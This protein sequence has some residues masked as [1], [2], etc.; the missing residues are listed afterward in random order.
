MKQPVNK[1]KFRQSLL[2]RYLLIIGFA[3]LF[4]PLVFPILSIAYFIA[5]SIWSG[6]NDAALKYGSFAQLE[7]AWHAEAA[8]MGGWSAEQIN[9]RMEELKQQ[10]ADGEL[11]WVDADG[12]TQLQLP[13]QSALPAQWTQA[14]AIRFMKQS[15]GSDP[16]TVVSFL[17]SE[18]EEAAF[19]VIQMPRSLMISTVSSVEQFPFFS[20]V[21]IIL[22]LFAVLSLLFFRHI[23]K[24]LMRLEASMSLEGSNGLPT[25]VFVRKHDEIGQLEAAFNRMIDQL[26]AGQ[27]RE[28]EEEQLRKQLIANLSHDLRT[29][30]TVMG[31]QLYSLRKETKS[32]AGLQSIG[33]L[34]SKVADLS[35][36]IDN[37][38]SYTL[39]TSGRYPLK[40]ERHDV[41]RLAK[42]TA[43]AWYPLW[44]K[45][46]LEADIRLEP[47]LEQQPGDSAPPLIWL[48]DRDGFRRVLDN[49]I[50]NVVRHAKEGRYIGIG[51]EMRSGSP[52]LYIAD[53]GGGMKSDSESKGAGIG[54]AIAHYLTREMGLAIETVSTAQGVRVYIYPLRG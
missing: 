37:L 53:A 19:I 26:K 52:A 27:Q 38:L 43:A 36:L 42:E 28:R 33:L 34:E 3:I 11:F 12:R 22:G 1:P 18:H 21:L 10:Y 16:F 47:A 31:G 5:G 14:D 46:G 50:Q 41:L 45:E 35:G 30:L 15:V 49:L 48:V 24:R 44:E 20:V 32:A 25:P 23:R 17:G 9:A 29:P 7:T 2:S 8:S 51:A 4:I 39:M 40:L 54:L 6:G 13:Y